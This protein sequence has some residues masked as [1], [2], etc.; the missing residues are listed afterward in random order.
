LYLFKPTLSPA[1][2]WCSSTVEKKSGKG[3]TATHDLNTSDGRISL[4]KNVMLT[5]FSEFGIVFIGAGLADIEDV[6]RR[7][8]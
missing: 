5:Y 6:I 8:F 4:S 2:G 1:A 7:N 3:P